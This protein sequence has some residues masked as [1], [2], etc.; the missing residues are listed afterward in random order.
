MVCY[1]IKSLYGLKKS[2][3]ACYIKIYGHLLH[4]GFTHSPYHS[5]LYIDKV[6]SE[7]VI[8]VLLVDDIVIIGRSK[9]LVDNVRNDINKSF[10]MK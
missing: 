3:K 10:N 8:L 6:E 4:H 2:P 1:F 5:N 7:I 9:N